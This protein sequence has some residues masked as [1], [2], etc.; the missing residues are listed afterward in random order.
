VSISA[1]IVCFLKNKYLDYLVLD[2]HVLLLL[3]DI[4]VGIDD[5]APIFGSHRHVP[6]FAS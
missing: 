3:D 6:R 1:K 4:T 2:I 5:F